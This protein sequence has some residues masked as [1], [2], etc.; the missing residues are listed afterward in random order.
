MFLNRSR[1]FAF[2]RNLQKVIYYFSIDISISQVG[3]PKLF[4][5][6]I[7]SDFESIRQV[8]WC[9]HIGWITR[10]YM[11]ILNT[12]VRYGYYYYYYFYFFNNKIRKNNWSSII[13]ESYETIGVVLLAFLLVSHICIKNRKKR[14]LRTLRITLPI[15]TDIYSRS[16]SDFLY[17]CFWSMCI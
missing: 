5:S 7:H 6:I 11:C 4:F 12:D 17:L 8:N 1:Q 2:D 13:Y 16:R 15:K 3:I 10:I 14:S 9:A